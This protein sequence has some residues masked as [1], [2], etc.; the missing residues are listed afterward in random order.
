MRRSRGLGDVYKRQVNPVGP[1]S[2]VGPVG[3]VGP[4]TPV[5]PWPPVGPVGPVGPKTPVA[6]TSPLLGPVHAPE[7]L[8]TFVVPTVSP[9]LTTK[10]ELVAKVHF[11]QGYYCYFI[12]MLGNIWLANLNAFFPHSFHTNLH[13]YIHLKQI[14]NILHI[15]LLL[16]LN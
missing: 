6:P 3:P 14:E 1:V 12:F 7:E 9:F 2:P 8:M 5:A 13:Q 15:F 4:K 10:L 11:P 16:L